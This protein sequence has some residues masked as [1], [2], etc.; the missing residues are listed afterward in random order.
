MLGTVPLE[1][2]ELRKEEE[3]YDAWSIFIKS[4]HISIYSV[5][6]HLWR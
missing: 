3:C 4:V 5:D 2:G 1:G 6:Q